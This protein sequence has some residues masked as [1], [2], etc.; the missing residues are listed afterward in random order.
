MGRSGA[1]L[2]VLALAVFATVGGVAAQEACQSKGNMP[3][4]TV[5]G[6]IAQPNR[7]PLVET[8]DRFFAFAERRFDK[9]RS[10]TA[11][12][13]TAL[14]LVTIQAVSPY[15]KQ[16]HTLSGPTV[17][18]VLEA[19]GAKGGKIAVQAVDRY[20]VELTREE[21]AKLNPIL[22]L[23]KDGKPVGL[24]DV[25]PTYF[26]FATPNGPTEEDF[27]RMIWATVFIGVR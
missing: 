8:Q 11:D 1:F 15:D 2:P 26:T 24:G 9:A 20:E 12:E 13:L 27:N 17:A 4:L 6:D 22:A 23:C 25:G 3:I 19:A 7:G 16:T 5:A 14:G 18:S 21:V 10:F